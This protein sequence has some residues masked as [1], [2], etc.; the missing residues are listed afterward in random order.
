MAQIAKL[1]TVECR[2]AETLESF[3]FSLGAKP[4][5]FEVAVFRHYL[6]YD[7]VCEVRSNYFEKMD[8]FQRRKAVHD[9][10]Q[11]QLTPEDYKQI[12]RIYFTPLNVNKTRQQ[13]NDEGIMRTEYGRF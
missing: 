5:E 2:V 9:F 10:M 1:D 13:V 6:S 8:W 7:L 12:G 11:K 3:C 4:D